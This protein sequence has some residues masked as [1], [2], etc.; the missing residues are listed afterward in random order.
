MRNIFA[1]HAYITRKERR[2][3]S[4]P[5]LA[6]LRQRPFL[7]LFLFFT[8][9]RFLILHV[10]FTITSFSDEDEKNLD[11]HSKNVKKEEKINMN[12]IAKIAALA[13]PHAAR[14]SSMAPASDA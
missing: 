11:I 2:C 1:Q 4:W 5:A 7:F 3:L 14:P 12:K 9:P 13:A 8:R 6:I 10:G